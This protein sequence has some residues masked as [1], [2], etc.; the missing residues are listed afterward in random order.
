[1]PQQILFE[2]FWWSLFLFWVL[3]LLLFFGCHPSPQAEDLLFIFPGQNT[4]R[5]VPDPMHAP[6]G[7]KPQKSGLS[8]REKNSVRNFNGTGAPTTTIRVSG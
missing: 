1:M 7:S 8:Q 3:L 5:R 6:W 4:R 2:S